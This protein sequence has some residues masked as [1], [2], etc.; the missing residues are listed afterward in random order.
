M[1]AKG[2]WSGDR[3][4]EPFMGPI[5][6]AIKDAGIDGTPHGVTIYNRAYEQILKA[7][8]LYYGMPNRAGGEE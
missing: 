3:R 7:I 5:D 4:V 6:Q 2:W 1:S 8:T